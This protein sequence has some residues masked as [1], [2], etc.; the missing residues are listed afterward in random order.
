MNEV[1]DG[2][3]VKLLGFELNGISKQQKDVMSRAIDELA[4]DAVRKRDALR[5]VRVKDLQARLNAL[6]PGESGVQPV[7]IQQK[8]Q[9]D[10]DLLKEIAVQKEL[11]IAVSTGG[12]RIEEKNQEYQERR[13]KIKAYLLSRNMDDP[14]PYSDLWDWYGKWSSGD[15]PTY[16]SRRKYI[17]G[18]YQPLLDYLATSQ[19][20]TSQAIQE[21]TGWE[22]VD[23]ILY[24]IGK[25]IELAENE[26]DF[27]TVGLLCREVLI[28]LAQSVYHPSIH[29]PIDG[30]LPSNADADRMLGAFFAKEL[31]G[32]R[33]EA[34]RKLAKAALVLANDLQHRQTATFR[35][36]ALCAEAVRSITN[37]VAIL[38]GK[39][40]P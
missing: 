26:E 34:G 1:F 40:N 15:L 28:T 22:K 39:R 17:S 18:L 5:L 23:R 13:L 32:G 37:I 25:Q 31:E 33:N 16:Q 21:P 14:N 35:D 30:I 24:G 6:V 12:P 11:M 36:A 27:Q 4:S 10:L 20:R 9:G 7:N 38:A 29:K 8:I 19:H 3:K 2:I